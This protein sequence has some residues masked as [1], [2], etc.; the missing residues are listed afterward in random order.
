MII[1]DFFLGKRPL[2]TLKHH[3]KQRKM[4]KGC[5]NV[6]DRNDVALLRRH[7]VGVIKRLNLLIGQLAAVDRTGMI[8]ECDLCIT[9]NPASVRQPLFSQQRFEKA[10][11]R[12]VHPVSLKK[13]LR[14]DL[15]KRRCSA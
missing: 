11:V 12:R 6:A 13:I 8:S 14:K 1:L 2:C 7:G 3:I 5:H 10:V 15:A 4:V 9:I